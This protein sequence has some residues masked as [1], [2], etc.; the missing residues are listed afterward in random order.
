MLIGENKGFAIYFN[1]QTQ[2]YSVF[3]DGKFLI[4]GKH[5]LSKVKHYLD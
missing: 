1:C 5:K 2:E 3:K 4:G